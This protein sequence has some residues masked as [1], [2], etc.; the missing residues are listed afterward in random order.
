MRKIEPYFNDPVKEK[1]KAEAN[2]KPSP[3]D[4][5]PLAQSKLEQALTQGAA[6]KFDSKVYGMRI[7]KDKLKEIFDEKCAFCECN[8]SVGSHLDVEHYRPKKKYY[9]LGYEWSNLLLACPIC[10]RDNKKTKFPLGTP[11]NIVNTPPVMPSGELNEAKC[12]ILSPELLA[13]SP[14]LLHPAIHD[15][16]EHLKFLPN[17]DVEGITEEGKES[18][19]VFGLRRDKLVIERKEIIWDMQ[20]ELLKAVS[21]NSSEKLHEPIF[22]IIEKLCHRFERKKPFLGFTQAILNNFEEFIVQNQTNGI[23][24]LAEQQKM[25]N[26]AAQ[27]ILS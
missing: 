22:Q 9:W 12:H 26:A 16:S 17:G 25:M 23:V 5:K 6:H 2:K 21:T 14:L 1:L 18:I 24:F 4:N 10:N 27:K 13:E 11:S 7:V 15:P 19:K 20:V 3:S 8:I